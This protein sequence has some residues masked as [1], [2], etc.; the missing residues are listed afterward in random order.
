MPRGYFEIGICRGKS[1]INVGT[2]WRSAYQLGA[3][4]VFTIGQRYPQQASDTLATWRHIPY[5]EYKDYDCFFEAQPYSCPIIAVE[6]G[7][8]PLREF[9]HPQRCIYL[10]GAEDNGIPK[11]MLARCQQTVSLE[12]IRTESFNVAV[13]GALVMYDRMTKLS[14]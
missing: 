12:S 14:I 5:R 6:M 3:A 10:L 1:P 9:V 2:L 8:K 7:G 4:G 13:A 11:D